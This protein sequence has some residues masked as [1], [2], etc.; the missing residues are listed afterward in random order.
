ME[1]ISSNP[2]VEGG[3]LYVESSLKVV[4]DKLSS[5]ERWQVAVATCLMSVLVTYI[6]CWITQ[7][8]RE[9]YEGKCLTTVNLATRK[10]R[11]FAKDKP[12]TAGFPAKNPYEKKVLSDS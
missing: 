6:Y 2:Y 4:E 12:K 5:Y 3:L 11:I 1:N 10:S 9:G 8:I 7:F